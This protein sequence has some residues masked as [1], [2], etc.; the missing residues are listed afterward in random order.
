MGSTNYG[1]QTIT[2]KYKNPSTSESF[3]QLLYNILP[4]GIYEGGILTI[5]GTSLNVAP[6]TVFISDP[7]SDLAVRCST[8]NSYPIP[9]T[10]DTPYAVLRLSWQNTENNYVDFLALA[11]SSILT[12]SDIVLGKGVYV[13][14]NLTS[15]DSSERTIPSFLRADSTATLVAGENLTAGKICYLNSDG[16]V[17]I[18]SNESASTSTGLLFYSKYDIAMNSRGLFMIRGWV[19]SSAIDDGSIYYLGLAGAMTLTAPTAIGS[20]SRQ[21]GVALSNTELYFSP[22]VNANLIS[23]DRITP[24]EAMKAWSSTYAYSFNEVCWYLGLPYKS[25]TAGTGTNTNHVP[26]NTTWWEAVVTG[27]GTSSGS[28]NVGY[29]FTNGQ[30]ETTAADWITYK[31]TVNPSASVPDTGTGGTV[32]AVAFTRNSSNALNGSYDGLLTKVGISGI[33]EGVAYDFTID[34]GSLSVPVQISFNYKTSNNS[35][36]GYYSD[37]YV[38]IYL[39]DKTNNTII[40]CNITNIP[41]TY[42]AVGY[43]QTL[44]IPST[45]TSY[46]IILHVQTSTTT[47]WLFNIDNVQ[48]GAKGVAAGAAISTWISYLPTAINVSGS[49]SQAFWKREGSDCLIKIAFTLSSAPT[50]IIGFNVLPAGLTISSDQVQLI[51]RAIGNLSTVAGIAQGVLV[52]TSSGVINIYS[53]AGNWNAS[54][55]GAWASGHT[56]NLEIRVPISQ[57]TSNVNLASDFSEFAFNSQ[58][59]IN[60]SDTSSFGIGPG[61]AAILA[62][63][64]Q[65]TYDAQFAKEIQ[66]TD[67]VFI[68]VHSVINGAWVP[69]EQ[70]CGGWLG[71]LGLTAYQDSVYN[72]GFGLSFPLASKKIVR[73]IQGQWGPFSTAGTGV[74]F[75]SAVIPTYDRWRVRKV[76][77]GNMAEI[78]SV[79]RAEYSSATAVASGAYEV[80]SLK[81]EDTHGAYNSTTGLFTIP[82]SGIYELSGCLSVVA[83]TEVDIYRNGIL[84]RYL[85]TAS[86]RSL[87]STTIRLIQ[88]DTI[89][90]KTA[91]Q[92]TVADSL[93]FI[94]FTWLGK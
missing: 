43:F 72:L 68:E 64:V 86:A 14:N 10:T 71:S 40:N 84:Y 20:V 33:G 83:T 37:D 59:V 31:N 79:V 75:W 92:S 81:V 35:T 52:I 57:W 17:Y 32:S 70:A 23:A 54:V 93:M 9:I 50:G 7:N 63:T 18:A 80:Y 27:G 22:D 42:G 4:V 91:S 76:S 49:F 34:R 46:R 1:S 56:I 15:I 62:N 19:P 74:I 16:K 26:T 29:N 47:K 25:L 65:T 44:F 61:G 3:N 58:S 39:Y 89:G 77:N 73:V 66:A 6:L 51:S 36:D 85:T 24:L 28:Y 67:H 30:F 11:K 55:P 21:I 8:V 5:S 2:W 60:T 12:G 88:G 13:D 38:G 48:V 45:S 90:I 53:S 94:A 87:Y 69:V 78:P 41:A 82:I